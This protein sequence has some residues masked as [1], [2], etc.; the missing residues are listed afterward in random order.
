V[1]R[2]GFLQI[3]VE[4][5]IDLALLA[6]AKVAHEQPRMAAGAVDEGEPASVRRGRRAD[7]AARTAGDRA[8]L[9]G[10]D[11]EALDREHLLVR[12]LRIFEI[13]AG[14]GVAAEIDGLAVRRVSRL[15]ELLLELGIGPF[16]QGNAVADAGDVVEPDLA[17]T[18]RP[19]RREM[20]ARR[21]IL[22]VGAPGRRVQQAEGLAR[23]LTDPRPVRVHHPDIVAAA[24]VRGEGD[25]LP[26]RREAG[27][28]VEGEAGADPPRRAAGDRHNVNVAEQVEGDRPPVRA[29]VNVHPRALIDLDRHLPET[30]PRRRV[31][32]PGGRLAAPAAPPAS[33]LGDRRRGGG[34]KKQG[35]KRG[36]AAEHGL[37][38]PSGLK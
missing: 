34:G 25:E 30:L 36:K 10:R 7:R 32:V 18:E 33:L 24:P 9:A 19:R 21:D 22:P 1:H 38:T 13:V 28:H 12:I 14:R 31:H 4:V 15:A 26:V 35:G 27:L 3:L 5:G 6:R 2:P 8:A 29:D 16:D 20:L 11:V 37:G 17:G 23:D